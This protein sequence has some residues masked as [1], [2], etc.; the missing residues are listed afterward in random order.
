MLLQRLSYIYTVG[1]YRQ[2]PTLFGS[3]YDKGED[4]SRLQE[5][6]KTANE[7]GIT[8]HEGRVVDSKESSQLPSN[9]LAKPKCSP[10]YPGQC[11]VTATAIAM[12]A[13]MIRMISTGKCQRPLPLDDQRLQI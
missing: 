7:R 12:T 4:D 2:T 10:P 9:A 13:A 3:R 11:L 5:A 6:A 1:Q 8:R